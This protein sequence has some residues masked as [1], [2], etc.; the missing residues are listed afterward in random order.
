M[1]PSMSIQAS[2][3]VAPVGYESRVELLLEFEQSFA[4]RLEPLRALV[5][6]QG[7]QRRAAGAARVLEHLAEVDTG[8][9]DL[10]HD[11]AGRGVADG[12]AGIAAFDPAP[13]DVARELHGGAPVAVRA[14]SRPWSQSTKELP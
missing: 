3:R 14:A 2:A 13:S 12:D 4:E 7:A 10:G 1:P 6:G 5:K 9:A 11:R 8:G